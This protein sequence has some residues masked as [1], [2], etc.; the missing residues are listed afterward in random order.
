MPTATAASQNVTHEGAA[1]AG[2]RHRD[3]GRRHGRLGHGHAVAPERRLALEEGA[4]TPGRRLAHRPVRR[5]HGGRPQPGPHSAV[6]T[7]P[8]ADAATRDAAEVP[9]GRVRGPVRRRVRRGRPGPP[10]VGGGAPTT[11]PGVLPRW[12]RA[13]P[14]GPPT[15]RPGPPPPS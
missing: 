12:C 1:P 14:P 10:P 8:A 9:T 13:L 4:E 3:R 6:D 5:A 7:D 11:P 15:A 2:G